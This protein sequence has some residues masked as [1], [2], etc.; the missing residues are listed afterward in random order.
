MMEPILQY[1]HVDISYTGQVVVQDISFAVNAGEILSIVG[2]SGSGKSTLLKGAMDLLGSGGLV[3]RGDIWFDG[4]N[5]PDISDDERR[6]LLGAKLAMIWQDAGAA[7]CPIRTI[8]DQCIETVQAHQNQRKEDIKKSTLE[9]FQKLGFEQPER[10]WESYSFELSGG[11]NQRVGIAMAALLRPDLILADEP[12]SALDVCAQRQVLD[13]LLWLRQ[14]YGTAIVIV[15]H[16]MGVVRAVADAVLVLQHGKCVE[17]GAATEV[18]EEPKAA[19]T[20]ALLAATPELR[21]I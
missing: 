6:R 9:L 14:Q 8:G 19:Y 10:I 15:T 4:K 21:R 12:T 7:L 16:D 5:L 2:E 17:Y 3:S 11:M 18:L 1:N 13:E 20:K